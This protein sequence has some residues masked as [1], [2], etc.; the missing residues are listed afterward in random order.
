VTPCNGDL[1][2]LLTKIRGVGE[3]DSQRHTDGI[4]D[5]QQGDLIN[6]LLLF[7]NKESRLK[8]KDFEKIE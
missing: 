4:T 2:S 8:R 1:I 5:R 6:L 7:Q 3:I